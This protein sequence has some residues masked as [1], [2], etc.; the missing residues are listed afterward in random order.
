MDH[1]LATTFSHL[2]TEKEQVIGLLAPLPKQVN[3]GP[4]IH[5]FY[6]VPM[7][8]FW[9]TRG[10]DRRQWGFLKGS[11]VSTILFS[12]RIET[13]IIG[14]SIHSNMKMGTFHHTYILMPPVSELS[15]QMIDTCLCF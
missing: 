1:F 15:Y 7:M 4:C 13:T 9:W 3:F 6:M 10:V 12:S 5:S 8:L 2:A 14:N 11:T